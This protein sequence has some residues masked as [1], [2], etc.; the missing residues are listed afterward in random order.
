MFSPESREKHCS[1]SSSNERA[2]LAT[3]TFA[4]ETH[5]PQRDVVGAGLRSVNPSHSSAARVAA[6][7]ERIV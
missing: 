5:D 2:P 1:T 6:F 4:T 3:V 7:S